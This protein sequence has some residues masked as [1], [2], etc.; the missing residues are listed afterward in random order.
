MG[1]MIE[2]SSKV[3][4]LSIETLEDF[5]IDTSVQNGRHHVETF[6]GICVTLPF[7]RVYLGSVTEDIVG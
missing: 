7:C 3:F 5:L 2:L 4:G 6:E 1:I